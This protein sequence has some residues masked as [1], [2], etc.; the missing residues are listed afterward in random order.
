M[1]IDLG[2]LHPE[3]AGSQAADWLS[4]EPCESIIARHTVG[5]GDPLFPEDITDEDRAEDGLP[6]ALSDAIERYGLTHFKVKICGKLEVDIPRLI[7]IAKLLAEKVPGYRF[8]L[9]G[10]EQYHDLG[11]FREHWEA[12]AREVALAEFL[13]PEHLI[14][15]EQ[16]LF[17]DVALAPGLGIWPFQ[18]R[19]SLWKSAPLVCILLTLPH[20]GILHLSQYTPKMFRQ[21]VFLIIILWSTNTL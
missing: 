21:S 12:F 10:N 8:T 11:T 14:F 2:A 17:R 5:L 3:L 1:G 15:V 19:C 6:Q 7:A 4:D 13:S 18:E 16:P 20:L 9:D